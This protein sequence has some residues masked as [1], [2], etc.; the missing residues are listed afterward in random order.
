MTAD[1]LLEIVEGQER[2][3]IN[4]VF[5]KIMRAASLAVA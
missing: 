5:L 3:Q 2:S 1:S 4:T